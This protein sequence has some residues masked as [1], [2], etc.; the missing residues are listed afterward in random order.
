MRIA[1]HNMTESP[2]KNQ[3]TMSKHSKKFSF[4]LERYSNT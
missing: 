3:L 2:K 1:M 4:R